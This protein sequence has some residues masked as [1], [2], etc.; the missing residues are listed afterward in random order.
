MDVLE[1]MLG[2]VEYN[3]VIDNYRKKLHSSTALNKKFVSQPSWKMPKYLHII[4][5][6]EAHEWWNLECKGDVE[7]LRWE[8]VEQYLSSTADVV[9]TGAPS[10]V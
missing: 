8:L 3:P 6:R 9:M 1:L 2:S 4:A 10:V 7:V 5:T